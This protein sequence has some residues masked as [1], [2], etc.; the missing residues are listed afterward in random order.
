MKKHLPDVYKTVGFPSY[1]KIKKKKKKQ[2]NKHT[3][4]KIKTKLPG[5]AKHSFISR[6]LEAET[7]G[8]QRVRAQPGLPSD[9]L[10]SIV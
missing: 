9:L 1:S 5:L 8:S 6:S 7:G 2:A 3:N 10:D 4:D